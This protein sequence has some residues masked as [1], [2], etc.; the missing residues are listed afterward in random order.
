MY[1][2]C[3]L[4]G[5]LEERKGKGYVYFSFQAMVGCAHPLV[6]FEAVVFGVSRLVG[7]SACFL[8]LELV[9]KICLENN[10]RLILSF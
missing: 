7:C 2:E 9:S 4:V 10:T 5:G 6:Y 1:Q 3:M 8:W